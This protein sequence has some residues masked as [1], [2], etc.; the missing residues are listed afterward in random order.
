MTSLGAATP[1]SAILLQTDTDATLTDLATEIR[2]LN[3]T[4]QR[5]LIDRSDQLSA[6]FQQELAELLI[7]LFDRVVQAHHWR[8]LRH[9]Y[10]CLD[11]IGVDPHSDWQLKHHPHRSKVAH[12]HGCGLYRWLQ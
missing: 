3:D 12:L 5:L 10:F 11:G 7:Q 2:T 1:D 8:H 6:A 4:T 9:I